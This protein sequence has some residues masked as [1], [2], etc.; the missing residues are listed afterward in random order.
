MILRKLKRAA[1]A[2]T[3][4][5]VDD[6]SDIEPDE[7][8]DASMIIGKSTNIKNERSRARHRVEDIDDEDDD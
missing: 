4:R 8:A 7:D 1:E 6:T 2:A 3:R 5:G